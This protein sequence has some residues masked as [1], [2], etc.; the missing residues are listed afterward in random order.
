MQSTTEQTLSLCNLDHQAIPT[1]FANE[2]RALFL[3]DSRYWVNYTVV[4]RNTGGLPIA[5]SVCG[6]V[7]LLHQ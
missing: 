1:L 4:N 5:R 7:R 2:M 6:T 3:G